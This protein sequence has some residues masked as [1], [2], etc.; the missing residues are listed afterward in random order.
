MNA[1][2][3]FDD[4]AGF[5][6]AVAR[7]F[8]RAFPQGATTTQAQAWAQARTG[9]DVLVSAP[10]GS[11][12][13]LSAFLVAL[14][15]LVTRGERAPLPDT[16]QVLY[17]S[18]LK[19]LSND[20]EK[21]LQ[22]PLNG[23]RD[24]LFE[25]GCAD[26]GIRTA[27]RTGDT[28]ASERAL[29]RRLPP[30]VLVTT[31]ESLFILL[32]S[33]SG[34]AMLGDVRTVIVDE[35]HALAG[36]K[37][38]AHLM[39]SL[40][41]LAALGTR[42]PARIGLSATVTPIAEV[43]DYL[44]GAPAHEVDCHIVNAG[45]RR[46]RD[47]ALEMPGS[48]LDAVMSAEV[49]TEIYDRLAALAQAHRT[50]L[51]FVNQRRIAERVARHLAE[52]LGDEHV[53]AHHGSLAREHRLQAEQRLKAGQLK[54]L[55]ATSSL[56]LGIDIG[57][58]DLV[59][60]LGSPRWISAFLQRVGRAGHAVGAVSKGRLFPLT[61]D[62]LVE[63]V[64]LL[65][66]VQRG[67]LDRN[68]D[69]GAPLDVLSQQALAEVGCGEWDEDALFDLVRR[70]WPYRNLQR[71]QFDAV[72]AMLAEGYTTRRGRRGAY[73]H[74]DA[75]NRR[76]RPRRGAALT[77][78]TNA[79][80]IPDQF[81]SDVILL[82]EGQRIGSLNEDF[83]F[84][85]LPG[86]IFQLGN[87]AYRITKVE[88]GKVLVEDAHGQPPTLP[89][90]LGEALGR[91]DELSQAV[92][93]LFADMEARLR[94]GDERD[95]E[96]AGVPATAWQQLR[97]FLGAAL[98]ALGVLPTRGTVVFERFFDEVGDA[99]L[100]IHSPFGSR[101]NKAW[102]L[103]LRKRFC[104]T[105]NFELQ[106]SALEDS[107]ILSLGPTHSF[108]LDEVSRYL[109][110]SS[111]RDVL[112]QALLDVP[113]FP[114][115]F[116]WVASVALAIRRMNGGRR[117]P[118][119]FQRSDAEDLLT[120]VFPDQVACLENLS[121]PREVPDHPLVAQSL[122]DCL[123]DTMDVDGFLR[124]VEGLS[125]GAIRVVCADLTAPSPLAGAILNA[126]PYAFLDDGEAEERR[127]RAVSQ[128]RL[129]E[130]GNGEVLARLDPAATA[131]VRD[132]A[133]PVVRDADELHD[134]LMVHGFL[135]A[136]EVRRLGEQW[137]DVLL[138]AGRAVLASG[139]HAQC[140]VATERSAAFAA[141]VPAMALALPPFAATQLVEAPD[142]A[143]LELVRGRLELLGPTTAAELAGTL[144]LP[145]PPVEAALARLEGEGGA[146]RGRFDPAIDGEQWCDRRLLA[147]IHRLCRQQRRARVQAVPPAQFMRFLLHWHGLDHAGG[148]EQRRQGEGGLLAVIGQLEGWVAP[149]VAWERD[150]LPA[151]LRDYQP[152]L[153]DRLCSSGQVAWWRPVN[154][155]AS[156]AGRGASP[157]RSTPI[158]LAS[159]GGLPQWRAQ[160]GIGNA[161][162]PE[163]SGKARR[164]ADVLRSHGALF[165]DDLQHACG[166]IATELEAALAELVA[167]GCVA[168]DSF[169][170]LRTLVAPAAVRDRLHRRGRA[171]DVGQA[172]RWALVPPPRPA[173]AMSAG[174]LADPAVEHI[175]RVLLRRYGVVF[176]ALLARESC[177]P[178]WRELHY[179]YRRMEAREEVQGGRF[180]DGFAGEQFALPEAA[181]ALRQASAEAGQ[182]ALSAADPLNLLGILVGGSKLPATA[183]NRILLA[184]GIPVAALSGSQVRPLQAADP[185]TTWSWHNALLRRTA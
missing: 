52:R 75:V 35:L 95:P 69:I 78:V 93:R 154:G 44:R 146:M 143:L 85:S 106:A 62:D 152:A 4:L 19:A 135:T 31:P 51:I 116:R 65:D 173:P 100:V 109:H 11:G 53:T 38:G 139:N 68:R 125:T 14:D 13:T 5:H 92:S 18:P 140:L 153:L 101:I 119:Q 185:A 117:V 80:V 155:E 2:P 129:H 24:A 104:R 165:L 37:R 128:P 7:W 112:V 43:A 122:H 145:L 47:L 1:L 110:P 123:H 12:K 27:V 54:A 132:E 98:G 60:Q 46:D 57:D 164:V 87:T 42:R 149:A 79:G 22:A 32:T 15:E 3:D 160:A 137:R 126:R 151:R 108:P 45:H 50:T 134:A 120:V 94:E 156:R 25:L 28:S 124:L 61:M 63:S 59:C 148:V 21:N 138:A 169:A 74:H 107:I 180:V 49:W 81:D 70:A 147:R 162:M 16:V 182:L 66:A 20:I 34:R 159:R 179:V 72:V 127:T 41:R 89:F 33:T 97:A 136:E 6:P 10:T 157:I 184:D 103:A 158:M 56:E 17:V 83:A 88:T 181:A 150:L 102:G 115:R 175:A 171:L 166:L 29:M 174:G 82:P 142:A 161:P 67:E 118:P 77:A 113:M 168:C 144:E 170:G 96:V 9:A 48:A 40:E 130:I 167:G 26:V 111:A 141:A 73:L 133:W 90:W 105:F 114:T 30:H 86:D 23:I 55:V 91:S 172:G 121:G 58:V 71:A 178:P 64:A 131:Q 176:R 39:L 177:L 99:H 36:S 8:R 84:E 163:M 76:L 183:R